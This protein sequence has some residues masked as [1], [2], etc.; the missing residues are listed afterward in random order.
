MNHTLKDAVNDHG[1]YGATRATMFFEQGE[2]INN[3]S[4]FTKSLTLLER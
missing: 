2:M 4:K 1:K 3:L